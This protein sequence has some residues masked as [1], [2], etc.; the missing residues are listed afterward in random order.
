MSGRRGGTS[1]A[2]GP[3]ADRP[4]R[5]H[6][7]FRAGVWLKGVD[8]LL[9][10]AGGIAL[11]VVPRGAV[12]RLARLATRRELSEDPR[13]PVANAILAAAHHLAVD[14]HSFAAAYLVVH[15]AVKLVLVAG[16]LAERRRAFPAALGVLGLFVA[17]QIYRTLATGSAVLAVLTLVDIGIIGLVAREWRR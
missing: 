17:Y 10:L 3:P 7:L 14:L 11:A 6:R 13:D 9:E 5:L 12:L 16:L 2:P 1:A 15:G 4:D 8:G